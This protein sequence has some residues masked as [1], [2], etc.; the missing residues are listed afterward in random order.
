MI[1][2]R[3]WLKNLKMILMN[4]VFAHRLASALT[5]VVVCALV[6]DV[7]ARAA[8]AQDEGMHELW[9]D[10]QSIQAE[11]KDPHGAAGQHLAKA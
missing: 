8:L 9:G 5:R 1:F 4:K 6:V 10:Q 2:V 11:L 7:F 3:F